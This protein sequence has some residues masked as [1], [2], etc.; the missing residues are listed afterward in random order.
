MKKFLAVVKREYLQRVRAKMFIVSTILLPV[1]M[2]LFGLVPAIILS[3]DAG[4]PIRVA[5]VDQTGKTYEQLKQAMSNDESEQSAN[6][7][8]RVPR[9]GFGNFVLEEVNA[10]DKSA[11]QI[12]AEL[13]RRLR[14]RELD[15]YVILPP[16]FLNHGQAEFFNR[17]PGDVI[18]RRILQSALNRA[19]REQRLI[20]AKVDIKTRRSFFSRWNCKR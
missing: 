17:N 15:G 6:T 14:D 1:V 12:R 11:D 7:D 4:S 19:V 9:R 20:E 3:I 10:A 13:D 2:S 18:S 8:S 16:D 5:V